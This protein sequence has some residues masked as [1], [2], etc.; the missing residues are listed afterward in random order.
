MQRIK[1]AEESAR[2]AKAETA[3]LTSSLVH[4]E[5]EHNQ[6]SATFYGLF[7]SHKAFVANILFTIDE[8]HVV[9][10]R[11]VQ[12]RSPSLVSRALAC[13]ADIVVHAT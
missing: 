13:T 10:M 4:L 5:H 9:K 7:Q 12:S 2:S 8:H 11:A 1:D 3:A 6:V